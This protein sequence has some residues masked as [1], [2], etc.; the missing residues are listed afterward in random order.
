[1]ENRKDI[2]KAFREKLNGLQKSPR[3]E[4]WAA[5][6]KELAASNKRSKTGIWL[7]AL[8][9][10]GAFLILAIV[11]SYPLW[12]SYAPHI[13]ISMPKGESND[14]ADNAAPVNTEG[15]VNAND[16][17]QGNDNTQQVLID[18]GNATETG[19]K[20]VNN[21]ISSEEETLVHNRSGST[22][23][24]YTN[25]AN[26]TKGSS[27]STNSTVSTNESIGTNTTK[28]QSGKQTAGVKDKNRVSKRNAIIMPDTGITLTDSKIAKKSI[29]GTNSGTGKAGT[30]NQSLTTK[31]D[32]TNKTAETT[33]RAAAIT[34]NG[35]DESG[36]NNVIDDEKKS[37]A[38]IKPGNTVN[39]NNSSDEENEGENALDNTVATDTASS[40][41]IAS[42][43]DL[44]I[45]KIAD[46]LNKLYG[47]KNKK[48]DILKKDKQ[49]ELPY[50][51]FYAY[52]Y[53][54]PIK[55]TF[56]ENAAYIDNSLR[57][58]LSSS[59]ASLAYGAS[60]GFHLSRK[61][62][63][64]AGIIISKAEMVTNDISFQNTYVYHEPDENNPDGYTETINPFKYR[65]IVYDS[66]MTNNVVRQQLANGYDEMDQS[67]AIVNIRNQF[68]FTEFPLEVVYRLRDAKFGIAIKG[69]V[70]ARYLK[71]N[72]VFAENEQG[73]ILLGRMKKLDKV[74]Y[75]AGLGG[76]LYYEIMPDLQINLEPAFKY[77]FD[78][79]QLIKPFTFS[80]QA[81]IQ[82]NFDL[83]TKKQ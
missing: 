6:N 76:S 27:L 2:G 31:T 10:T 21:Q 48:E 74:N 35:S 39:S 65:D 81:G 51:T 29:T 53:V 45:A 14:N 4:G 40:P 56:P 59:K 57:S 7:K 46:S 80:I 19:N 63:L 20:N 33:Q 9:F 37:V 8:I 61:L 24:R 60:L 38:G 26:K 52:G 77:Y 11:F 67:T 3:N 64:R 44:D 66:G 72:S 18:N 78:K 62:S 32:R 34:L 73:S 28:G 1:M 54:A 16:D 71:D 25:S 15:A 36:N 13:Y 30:T 55:Y 50:K 43:N 82:Y 75:S 41:V 42:K 17:F 70:S 69:I 49:K 5:I 79:E 12:K 22:E 68:S 83:F 58:N 23:T 47:G